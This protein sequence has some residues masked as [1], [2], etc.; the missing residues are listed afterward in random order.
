MRGHH[1]SGIARSHQTTSLCGHN[2]RWAHPVPPSHCVKWE[3]ELGLF[4]TFVEG[5]LRVLSTDS[6]GVVG[7]LM[8]V[9]AHK[10]RTGTGPGALRLAEPL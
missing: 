2:D 6:T 8:S 9:S 4:K 1:L 3:S 10:R 5:Q 7:G